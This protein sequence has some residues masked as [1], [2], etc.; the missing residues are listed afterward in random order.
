MNF[1]TFMGYTE[2]LPVK[3]NDDNVQRAHVKKNTEITLEGYAELF[4]EPAGNY[5][6]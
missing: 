6:K 3:Y 1:G 2:L 4:V 5:D